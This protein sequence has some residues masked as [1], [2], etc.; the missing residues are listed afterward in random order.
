MVN[1][2]NLT[3]INQ[4]QYTNKD[5]SNIVKYVNDVPLKE[6]KE[7]GFSLGSLAFLALFP[8][9]AS[10]WNGGKWLIRNRKG[11]TDKKTKIVGKGYGETL[12]EFFENNK[13][14]FNILKQHGLFGAYN[15]VDA[16]EVLKRFKDGSG[17]LAY[18]K[19]GFKKQCEEIEKLAESVK[20]NPNG[21]RSVLKDISTKVAELER[22]LYAKEIGNSK[23]ILKG[24]KK[25]ILGACAKSSIPRLLKNSFR[26][27]GGLLIFGVGSI[28]S[29]FEVFSTYK[30]NGLFSA[31]KQS[32]KSMAE[33]VIGLCGWGLGETIG[34]KIFKVFNI[35]TGNIKALSIFGKFTEDFGSM[36]LGSI[37]DDVFRKGSK[38]VLGK[39][40][41]EKTK[42][43]RAETMTKEV[44]SNPEALQ[45]LAL[46]AFEKIGQQGNMMNEEEAQIVA[47]SIAKV[48]STFQAQNEGEVMTPEQMKEFAKELKLEEEIDNASY[49]QGMPEQKY[50]GYI[51]SPEPATFA[52]S[53]AEKKR[54][55]K[56]K[57]LKAKQIE[58]A[59]NNADNLIDYS[60][61]YLFK[62]H[63]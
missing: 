60:K 26:S 23:G 61:K 4:N 19:K 6:E 51:P 34:R 20:S 21:K 44:Q 7:E 59:I 57:K 54:I 35:A 24:L 43:K 50:T 12:K 27:G 39:S 9:G 5:V 18:A 41:L 14:K 2:I 30:E 55:A 25:N 46:A 10:I 47:N 16:Q 38:K 31:I 28:I 32:F 29:G 13:K 63:D 37:V 62:N 53:N 40:E 52:L 48:V 15:Y 56:E 58:D 8:V 49:L 11:H 17:D 45:Q 22:D 36:I 3:T 42:E 33:N 1:N